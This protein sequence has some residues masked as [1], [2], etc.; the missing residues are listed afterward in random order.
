MTTV[1]HIPGRRSSTSCVG[2]SRVTRSLLGYGVLAGPIYV[3]VSL[4]QA[5]TRTGFDLTRHAWSLLSTGGL[6]WIQ[7]ANFVVTGLMIVA[8]AVG[9]GRAGIVGWTPRLVAGYG[10][11]MVAAG[12]FRAD[13]AEG[14]PAGTS[15]SA[16]TVSW[17][18]MLHLVAGS[19]GFGCLIAACLVA[20]R[21]FARAG[22][23]GW[24]RY[25]RIAGVVLLAGFAGIAS[26]SHGAATTVP[27]TMSVVLVLSWITAYSIRA[28]RRTV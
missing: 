23:R 17:H 27:F 10:L 11:G 6:G 9:L 20:G 14:F 19:V 4:A 7:V 8:A 25:S 13:P 28:Y 3:A 18:G 1:E 15:A 26:G 16:N 21:G 2:G 22:R 12:I 24:A 5:L